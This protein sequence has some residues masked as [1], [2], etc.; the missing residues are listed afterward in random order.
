MSRE[1]H[2]PRYVSLDA[3]RFLALLRVFLWHATGWALLTWVAALPT[4]MYTTGILL[5]VSYTKGGLGSTLYRRFRRFLVPFWVYGLVAVGIMSRFGQGFELTLS[6]VLRWVIPYAAPQGADWTLGWLS[7]PLWYLAAY[8]WLLVLSPLIYIF[9]KK[10]SSKVCGLC[11]FLQLS[12]V[13]ALEYKYSNSLWLLQDI[14]LYGFFLYLGMV[15]TIKQVT[16]SRNKL[17]LLMSCAGVLVIGVRIIGNYEGYVV[18]DS[19]VTHALM[20]LVCISLFRVFE[21]YVESFFKKWGAFLRY[22]SSRSLTIYMWHSGLIALSL[23]VVD[24]V[25]LWSDHYSKPL[26][27]GLALVTTLVLAHTVGSLEAYSGRVNIK[28]SRK[29]VALS[30]AML[31]VY[32]LFASTVLLSAE[33]TYASTL[34][35]SPSRAP[36]YVFASEADDAADFFEDTTSSDKVIGALNVSGNASVL[37]AGDGSPAQ[38]VSE[39][40]DRYGD[41]SNFGA[42][43]TG[44]GNSKTGNGNVVT[45]NTVPTAPQYTAP[46]YTAPELQ[47]TATWQQLAP[48]ASYETRAIIE[49]IMEKHVNNDKYGN[50]QLVVVKPGD[51]KLVLGEASS[52]AVYGISSVTKSFTGSLVLRAIAEGKLS[53]DSKLGVL[54]VAPWFTVGMDVTVGNLLTHRSGIPAYTSTTEYRND[55]ASISNWQ[56]ALEAVQ[57][58][59]LQF[60]PG[61]ASNYSSTNYILLGLLLEE[62]YGATIEHLIESRLLLPLGLD[63]TGVREGTAGLPGKGTGNMYS[64][65]GDLARW[66][67]AR[68]RT[69]AVVGVK[70]SRKQDRFDNDLSGYGEWGFCPCQASAATGLA[71]AA[72]GISGGDVTLRYYPVKD[73]IV[74]ARMDSGIWDGGREEYLNKI[75]TAIV[76]LIP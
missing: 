31:T 62:I 52:S 58:Y 16:F 7:G 42:T 8:T 5:A 19:H 76:A 75:I 6:R 2:S 33:P 73:V 18:N 24:K 26:S 55:P 59:P 48:D 54:A 22:I 3:L 72:I 45:T 36:T 41:P 49:S 28:V 23:I 56:K 71:Y 12:L 1:L 70:V 30:A 21:Q 34:P 39:S 9:I 37:H 4:L 20:G 69:D 65:L 29:S 67:N 51:Y 38:S 46:Q 43:N 27:I 44:P 17:L 60:E 14:A 40:R 15:T 64:S 53:L 68:W 74:V 66:V 13:A 10:T 50:L 25:T 61:T 32:G 11:G 63:A 35:V 47:P 57:L